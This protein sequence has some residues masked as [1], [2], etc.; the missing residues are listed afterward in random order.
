MGTSTFSCAAK[1]IKGTLP[2]FLHMIDMFSIDAGLC[3]FH[4]TCLFTW[5][6]FIIADDEQASLQA[7]L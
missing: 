3:G 1:A 5:L 6:F 7:L 4:S 2:Q